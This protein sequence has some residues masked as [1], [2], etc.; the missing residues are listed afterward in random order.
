MTNIA[1]FNPDEVV[2]VTR[3]AAEPISRYRIHNLVIDIET[4][5]GQAAGLR[6]QIMAN[7]RA[8]KSM[9]KPET[10]ALWEANERP[11]AAELAWRK[12]AVNPALGQIICI[13][14]RDASRDDSITFQCTPDPDSERDMLL[15]FAEVLEETY[16]VPAPHPRFIGHNLLAF[17]LPYI[18]A[19]CAIHKVRL[20]RW[21]P[22]PLTVKP[23]DT[24]S[25]MDTML[26][27]AGAR[28]KIKMDVLCG[29]LGIALKGS[30]FL[31]ADQWAGDPNGTSMEDDAQDEDD[32]IDMDGSKVWDF[33]NEGRTDLVVR[34][35]DGDV[36][37]TVQMFKALNYVT[38][39]VELPE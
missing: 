6:E 25:A 22:T 13:V 9:K 34:Y 30:E 10:I 23:W 36:D 26:M 31:P 18:F 3:E 39:G 24:R 32:A 35:C 14:M 20:P 19:R 12:T 8:P 33:V 17:D 16:Q 2:E 15:E 5:P 28:G 4:I 27:F 11:A 38:N 37:R 7:I 21:F 1:L 29:A